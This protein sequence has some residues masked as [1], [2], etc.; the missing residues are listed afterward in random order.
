[1]AY[2]ETLSDLGE[3][4]GRSGIEIVD[5]GVPLSDWATDSYGP[6]WKNQPSVRK[7]VG[8]IARQL[9]STPLHLFERASNDDRTRI[10]TGDLADLLRRPTRAPGI[11]PYRFWESLLIDGLINDRWCAQIVEHADGWELVRIPARRV[12]FKSDWLGRIEKVLITGENGQTSDH[13]PKNYLIDVGYSE[14]GANGTSPLRTLQD[15]LNE[16]TE[17]VAYRRAVWKNG[18][19]VPM[20]IE[21]PR[22]AGEF[23]E[24]PFARFKTSWR[25]F[26]KGGGEEGGTPILEDGMT[27][28]E[29][30]AF[31]PRD[32]LDLEGRKL[33]DIEVCSAY[34]I[35][36]ELVGAREGTFANIKAFKEMLYGPNLG[37]YYAAWEQ[38]LNATLVP[39]MAGGRAV[40][41]EANLEAKLRGSF[42]EQIDYLSTAVGGPVV[43]RA[44]ARS[45]LNLAHL[46]GTDEL[47]TP[48]NV[49]VGGQASPQDGE[50]AGGGGSMSKTA[51]EIQRLITSATALIRAGFEPQAS[52]SAVGLDPIA[53]LGLLPVTVREDEDTKAL[54]DLLTEFKARQR[55]VISSQKAAG[56]LDWWD[57]GR[58][59]GELAKALAKAGME[60]TRAAA[61]SRLVNDQS[62][63]E[64]LAE[65]EAS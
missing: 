17:S 5:P 48:L 15:I 25:S 45:R 22:E 4:L 52:L 11:T 1:M 8:F 51:E 24:G 57:R 42:D 21:R 65:G 3:H 30:T 10:R 12:R 58:W 36:P 41:I 56:V 37:P 54:T 34:Y 23:K 19:R 6:A 39:L 13:D 63:R 64:L 2:F 18:A 44:E 33:A 62:E 46:E 31:R 47:I 60:I 27:L 9:A 28:K 14:K 38:S 50:T 32:T 53:H 7:V 55:Q 26:V 29:I 40:Y 20:V 43:T 16:Q 35:A 59:D 61:V 49:L